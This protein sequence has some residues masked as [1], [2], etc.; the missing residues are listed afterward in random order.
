[1]SENRVTTADLSSGCRQATASPNLVQWDRGQILKLTGVTLPLAY[2]VEFTTPS[3]SEST[4]M[5]GNA[6]GVEIPDALLETGEPIVAYVVLHDTQNDRESE[7]WITI[8]VRTRQRPEDIAP[9]A[10]QM[11]L[12]DQLVAALD[13]GVDQAE[14]AA[15][16]AEAA[17]EK[18]PRVINGNW[19]V[20]DE[21]TEEWIDTEVP[22]T[23]EAGVGI[24][25]VTLNDDYTLTFT[26]TNG[27]DWTS[28]VPIRGAQGAT[29]A[30]GATPNLSI[31]TV[32]T[33]EA[34][35][36]AEASISGTP[37]NPVLNLGIPKGAQGQ[38]GDP[39]PS[40][41][42]VPAVDDWLNANVTQ[43][44][45]YVL[46]RTLE[47]SNAAAPAD[48]VGSLKSA[49]TQLDKTY[50]STLP[51]T[52]VADE[53]VV[54]NTGAFASY[55]GWSR[56]DYVDLS[57]VIDFTPNKASNYSAFY[58][59]NKT[60]LKDVNFTANQKVD[61]PNGASYLCISSATNN[62]NALVIACTK[63]GIIKD[64]QNQVDDIENFINS[65]TTIY[66]TEI[67]TGAYISK[68]GFL[69]T[70][71]SD[72][73]ATP[74]LLLPFNENQS[75]QLHTSIYGSAG[76]AIY[77]K[78]K[79]LLLGIDTTNMAT[80]GGVSTG[81]IQTITIPYIDGMM[82]ARLSC[83]VVTYTALTD[84]WCKGN[85]LAGAFERIVNLEM[86]VNELSSLVG[87]ALPTAKTLVIGDSISADEYG[88]Y[89]K[90]VTNLM[91]S[92]A[93]SANTV[94]SSQHATGFVARYNNEAN[95]FVTRL[96]AVQNPETYDLVVV[97]GGIN[98][99]IQNIP[100]G[101]ESGTDYT[102][103]FKPA[104]N[105]FFDYL[106]QNFTQA[107]LCV[108][109]P[110]R[111]YATWTNSVG[112]YQQAYGDYINQVAKS[113]CLPTLNLTEDS[114]FCPYISTFSDMWTL[115]PEGFQSHDGVHPNEEYERRFLAPMIKH[116]LQGLM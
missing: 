93:L 36:P 2:N 82:Y 30:T 58:D 41:E 89:P 34:G 115:L 26:F 43:E 14:A 101:S 108:L 33:L 23:G 102:V 32:S 114:G 91:N 78:N 9:D 62:M 59:E 83:R 57:S 10:D 7:Y 75:F 24:A 65:E 74:F 76:C 49:I 20:W 50:T 37:E 96:K 29:G 51:F 39:A 69:V 38:Q 81:E 98:D 80:Y 111:T 28:P 16:Q 47:M 12:I 79:E 85:S 112:E 45:G 92:G 116:F 61:V 40:A 86:G 21:A 73:V 100:M 67:I 18:Y 3:S 31:G 103:S 54:N 27:D 35:S 84:I 5:I 48:L 104:V 1:M 77:N 106:I 94:N 70:G 113:Y 15:A 6:D 17:V 95:D 64:I 110:L 97:F 42:V 87:S 72:F 71:T 60:Y 99:Y 52:L 105:E 68:L 13:E 22:A 46:D 107:R 4:T 109:L 66:P 63:N 90:W 55:G 8:V 19:Y 11:A 44:T 56:T 53:Y 88:N 25:S